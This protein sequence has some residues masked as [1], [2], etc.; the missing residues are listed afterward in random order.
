MLEQC[1]R[2]RAV[3]EKELASEKEKIFISFLCNFFFFLAILALF[4]IILVPGF[5]YAD[6]YS[7]YSL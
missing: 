1:D 3:F 5:N 4:N 7:T 2:A 6:A